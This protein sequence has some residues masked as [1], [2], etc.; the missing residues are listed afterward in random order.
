MLT[1]KESELESKTSSSAAKQTS[2]KDA[3]VGT[4]DSAE[5]SAVSSLLSADSVSLGATSNDQ[6][7]KKKKKARTCSAENLELQID[8]LR[9]LLKFTEIHYGS[10]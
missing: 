5:A 7:E 6:N 10:T 4:N 2:T 3:C 1:R 9:E 8:Q